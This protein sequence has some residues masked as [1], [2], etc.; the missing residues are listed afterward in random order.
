M[1]FHF[2]SHH[3]HVSPLCQQ[4]HYGKPH[5]SHRRV[6]INGPISLPSSQGWC[7]P[8]V[9]GTL[10]SHPIN[11][12][13]LSPAYP[14]WVWAP[15]CPGGHAP[16]S[17]RRLSRGCPTFSFPNLL[18]VAFEAGFDFCLSPL[19][20]NFPCSCR[21]DGQWPCNAVLHQHD[22]VPAVLSQGL[23]VFR[24]AHLEDSGRQWEGSERE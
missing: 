12:T 15:A 4:V 18:P 14:P 2:S 22:C 23:A 9:G 8:A 6:M 16:F 21:D 10:G 1:S 24:C 19:R 13:G 5:P 17:S 11:C 3:G 20:K 7:F